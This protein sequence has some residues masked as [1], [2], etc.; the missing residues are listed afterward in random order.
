MNFI[1]I[2]CLTSHT[3]SKMTSL[4]AALRRTSD[5]LG[6]I[7]G[8]PEMEYNT[9]SFRFFF[10]RKRCCCK[11]DESTPP[12][13][14]EQTQNS[15]NKSTKSGL[16]NK[17]SPGSWQTLCHKT[18]RASSTNGDAKPTTKT[19]EAAPASLLQR[20]P[21]STATTTSTQRLPTTNRADNPR[22]QATGLPHTS[23]RL[24][25]AQKAFEPPSIP[26]DHHA[27]W[28]QLLHEIANEPGRNT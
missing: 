7:I 1:L 23:K 21:V 5:Q 18:L 10:V 11:H 12:V 9:F 16:R 8:H 28:H 14:T 19:G 22:P 6:H 3:L 13:R 20:P 15:A 25:H 26:V 17:R 24:P 4:L 27:R 2:E